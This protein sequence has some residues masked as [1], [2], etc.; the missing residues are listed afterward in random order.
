MSTYT[1]WYFS[2]YRDISSISYRCHIEIEKLISILYTSLF[3]LCT[4]MHHYYLQTIARMYFFRGQEENLTQ[5]LAGTRAI[6][7]RI[8]YYTKCALLKAGC[9]TLEIHVRNTKM[10]MVPF[11][12][13]SICQLKVP[14]SLLASSCISDRQTE[15]NTCIAHFAVTFSSLQ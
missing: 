6:L 3:I 4:S 8:T 9:E 1:G 12:A 2:R 14:R 7:A 15:H 5:V 13:F 11:R 10:C